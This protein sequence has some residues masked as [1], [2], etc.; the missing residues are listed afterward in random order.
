MSDR[1]DIAYLDDPKI[2][3]AASV[4]TGVTTGNIPVFGGDGVLEDSHLSPDDIP[5]RED[6]SEIAGEKAGEVATAI[7]NEYA[8]ASYKSEP[9][10]PRKTYSEGDFCRYGGRGYRCI[11]S[12]T[13]AADHFDPDKW[14]MVLTQAGASAID[15]LLE[16]HSTSGLARLLDIADDLNPETRYEVDD[17]AIVNGVL[18]VCTYAATG[19]SAQFED[20]T[21]QDVLKKLREKVKKAEESAASK[22]DATSLD[23]EFSSERAYPVGSTCT[24][25][26]KLYKCI[27]EVEE[28][29]SWDETKW[30][31]STAVGLVKSGSLMY[32]ECDGLYYRVLGVRSS[33]TGRVSLGVDQEGK[34][35]D[36]I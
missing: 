28:G 26:G 31:E 11:S 12:H 34:R 15:G 27:F 7:A 9:W 6:M 33:A 30:E 5:S 32:V 8:I 14:E 24:H 2:K 25:G 17:L 16:G 19:A 22:V 13:S 35:I 21:V 4:A 18:K 20:A 36:E 3:N 10:E 29:Y 1:H 23:A